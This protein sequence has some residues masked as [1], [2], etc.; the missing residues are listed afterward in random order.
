VFVAAAHAPVVHSAPAQQTC[1]VPPHCAHEFVA[2]LHANGSPQNVPPLI[3]GQH[4]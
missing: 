3:A 1:P 2:L 4:G